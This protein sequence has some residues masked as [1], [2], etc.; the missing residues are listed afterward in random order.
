MLKWSTMEKILDYLLGSKFTMYM[1]NNSLAYIRE[2]RLG[3]AEIRLLSKLVLFDFDVKY[4]MDKSNKTVDA[5]RHCSYVPGEMDNG[6]DSVEYKTIS[7][8]TVCKELEEI[9]DGEKF[10]IECKVAIQEKQNKP[11]QQELEL[12]FIAIGVLNQVTPSDIK[13]AQQA[14]PTIN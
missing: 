11:A 9:I 5:L 3:L 10:P 7:Y 1:D 13:D 12:H 4:R 8:T 2:I 14:H 6:S